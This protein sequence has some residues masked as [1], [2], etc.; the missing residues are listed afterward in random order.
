MLDDEFYKKRAEHIRQ[1]A[2]NADEF[3]KPRLLKLAENY[4]RTIRSEPARTPTSL[5]WPASYPDVRPEDRG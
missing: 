5:G 1:I 3:I 2:R 4:E